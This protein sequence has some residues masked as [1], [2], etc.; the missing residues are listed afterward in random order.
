VREE[1]H[2]NHRTKPWET[3]KQRAMIDRVVRCAA[4]GS[5]VVLVC[6]LGDSGSTQQRYTHTPRRRWPP[7]TSGDLFTRHAPPTCAGRPGFV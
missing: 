4:D 1:G 2:I 3:R 5:H 6:L 7:T